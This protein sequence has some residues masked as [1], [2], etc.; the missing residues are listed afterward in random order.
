MVRLKP[1]SVMLKIVIN[2]LLVAVTISIG[3]AQI[4]EPAHWEYTVSKSEVD[5]GEQ[6]DLIFEVKIDKGWY[7]YSTDFDPDLGPMV[8]TFEFHPHSSYELVGEIKPVGSKRKYDDLW[9]GEYTYFTGKA[10]FRQTIKVLHSNVDIQGSYE[11]QVCT[12]IDGKCIPFDDKFVF[13]QIQVLSS[14]GSLAP[15]RSDQP[16][17]ELAEEEVIVADTLL[18]NPFGEPQTQIGRSGPVEEIKVHLI[19]DRTDANSPYSLLAFMLAAFLAG[20]VALL[21]PCVFPMIPMTVAFF[22]GKGTKVKGGLFKAL[23]YGFSIIFIFTLVGSLVAPFMGPEIAN[24]LATDWRP[25]L[26]FF[27]IFVVFGLSFLGLFEITLPSAF[28]NKMDRQADKGGLLGVFFMAFTLVLV[29]FSCTGPIVGSILVESA[30]G[31]VLKP[32][33]GMFAFSMAFALPFGFFALF[34]NLISSLPKSG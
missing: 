11:Y 19:T 3:Q 26:L 18:E 24:D 1:K 2:L 34:P 27:L 8:T 9:E 14:Y 12:E 6:V 28:I 15:E 7:L 4:L 5:Q 29:S 10:E 25:N 13:D 22:S 21:T 17:A 16:V 20:L 31:L 33:L 32:I 23:F 30:G